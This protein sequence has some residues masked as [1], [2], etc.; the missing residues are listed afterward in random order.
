MKILVAILTLI[1]I[2]QSIPHELR[3]KINK[4][5]H[6]VTAHVDGERGYRLPNTSY[7][8]SYVINLI[9]YL[10]DENEEER[11]KF[12]GEAWIHVKTTQDTDKVILHQKDLEFE[13]IEAY[14][15]DNNDAFL[16]IDTDTSKNE[17]DFLT[18][19]NLFNFT[20][21][22]NY[23]FYFK[24]QG[25]LRDD[26]LGFYRSSYVN[27][28]GKTVWL[29]TTQFQN[30]EARTAF[31]CYDEPGIRATFE[32][33][34]THDKEL[35]AISN[36]YGTTVT[37]DEKNLKTQFEVTPP[38]QTYLIAFIVSDFKNVASNSY[39]SIPQRV[40]AKPQSI[41]RG[42]AD[43]ALRYKNLKEVRSNHVLIFFNF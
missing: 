37:V 10:N 6:G 20:A 5:S 34:I 22:K 2:V 19:T 26:N 43:I 18:I 31:P 27:H 15:I 41:E 25:E 17:F 13:K 12:T 1:V 23:R 21:N 38:V 33:S 14:D 39:A 7:P 11:F 32:I 3:P 36:M 29:A 35:T 16:F 9:T 24:F 42:E 28:E 4:S 8:I 30:V 40:F